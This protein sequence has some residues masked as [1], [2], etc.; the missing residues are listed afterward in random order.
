MDQAANL[1]AVTDEFVHRFGESASAYLKECAEIAKL[2]GDL[3]SAVTWWDIVLFATELT[4]GY[5]RA[6]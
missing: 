2:T 5:D 6:E 4:G 1:A 3:E